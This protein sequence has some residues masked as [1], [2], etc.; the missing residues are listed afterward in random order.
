MIKKI[1]DKV[2]DELIKDSLGREAEYF[3][4]KGFERLIVSFMIIY[5]ISIIFL[6]FKLGWL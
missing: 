5:V 4:R 3:E 1:W 2:M 6:A